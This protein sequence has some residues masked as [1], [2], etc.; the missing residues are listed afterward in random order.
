MMPFWLYTLGQVFF[1]QSGGERLSIPFAN[2]IVSLLL[3]IGPVF[4]G[5]VVK[6]YRPKFAERSKKFVKIT[7]IFIIAVAIVF[8]SI[9]NF[10]VFYLITWKTL[11]CGLLLPWVGFVLSYLIA[12]LIRQ[13]HRNCR[14]IAIETGIQNAGIA[15]VLLQ[16]SLKPPESDLAMVMPVC[17][18]IFTP[19]PLV[20]ALIVKTVLNCRRLRKEKAASLVGEDVKYD[21]NVAIVGNIH[22]NGETRGKDLRYSTK[23][24]VGDGEEVSPS[25]QTGFVAANFAFDPN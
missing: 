9:S 14:T 10:Y 5:I 12:F 23:E 6:H 8:G 20:A 22:E 13:D 11:L 24:I 7:T 25:P 19:L 15:I 17:V 18:L 16:T 1:A 21:G 3:L 2:I 4:L